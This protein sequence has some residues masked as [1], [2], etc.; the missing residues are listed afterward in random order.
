[1]IDVELVNINVQLPSDELRIVAMQPFIKF[2]SN[3]EEPYQWTEDSIIAQEEA[4]SRTLDNA[5]NGFC[6]H[7]ANFTIFP[8]Y[9]V[10][11]YSGVSK[12]H[13]RVLSEDWKNDTIIIAGIHGILKHEYN[14]ICECLSA[15]V[16]ES[17]S[18]KSI[19]DSNWVNCCVI[20]V[21]DRNGIVQTWIQ[22]KVRPA[23]PEMDVTC[24]DMFCGSTIYVFECQYTP[25]GYPCRFVT[26]ICF[27]WVASI[28]GNTVSNEL[29]IKLTELRERIPTQLDLIF[30]IQHNSRPNHPS[31]LSTTF[32]FLTDNATHPFVERDKAIVFHANTAVSQNPCRY[33]FGGFSACVFSP[34]AQ[35]DCNPCRPTV[36]MKPSFIRRS[37]ILERCKDIVFR[38]MGECIHEFTIRVPRFVTP[39]AT[40]R[41]YPL[42]NAIVHGL[43]ESMDPR[44]SG[45]SVPAAVKWICDSLD[46]IELV[47]ETA[48]SNCQLQREA[49]II[50]PDIINKIR[51]FDGHKDENLIY[52]ATCRIIDGEDIRNVGQRVD[53]DKWDKLEDEA[54][55]HVIHSLTCVG[56]A[57]KISFENALLH[58]ALETHS[59]FIQVVAIR[60]D[61]H[62]DCQLHFNKYVQYSGS[63]PVI[64]ITHDNYDCIPTAD[65]YRRLDEPFGE[66]GFAFLDYITLMN[67]CRS[68]DNKESIKARI[69]DILPENSRII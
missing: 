68:A 17:N 41:T 13:K 36:Y 54:L 5:Q 8:E 44:L 47:S 32:R 39:D 22:P 65:E 42:P 26:L 43:H 18:S 40:D 57:Y 31:F 58:S 28:A 29:L 9:S 24:N 67:L 51:L 7:G 53:A 23:W 48:L 19:L 34:S 12:I 38:E 1:M 15:H 60:G 4:I 55:M 30:V 45:H 20:W 11:G 62:Q 3:T 49:Q 25:S 56:L 64:I 63:D 6:G 21:K 35:F 27:D 33:G 50:E 2:H 59:G 52:W 66:K 16:S 69:N 61:S 46:D 14:D 37:N 10:P